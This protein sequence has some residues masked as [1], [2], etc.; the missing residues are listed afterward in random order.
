MLH[1]SAVRRE[2]WAAMRRFVAVGS[3]IL[4]G[5]VV[6]RAD[7]A[8]AFFDDGKVQEIR[9]YF[10]ESNWYSTLYQAHN[11]NASDPCFPATLV[12][13]EAH[14]HTANQL[15]CAALCTSLRFR[16]GPELNESPASRVEF[17]TQLDVR[18]KDDDAF[19]KQHPDCG[20]CPGVHALEEELPH[21]SSRQANT[22]DCCGSI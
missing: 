14:A 16:R 12:S 7:K 22:P 1:M 9:L 6:A 11:S 5:A 2:V 20:S 19:S 15:K 3:L 13:P 4:L 21:R 18:V 17:N 10:T 8:D